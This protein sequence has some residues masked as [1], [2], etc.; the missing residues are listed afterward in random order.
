MVTPV[1]I[2]LAALG[3]PGYINLGH[4]VDLEHSYDITG[5]ETHAHSVL[6]TAWDNGIRYYDAARSYGL[7]E[8]FLS[9][10]LASR[11][12]QPDKVVVGSKWGYTYTAGWKVEAEKHEVK[13]H[14]L[15]VLRKQIEESRAYLGQYLKVYQIH[16]ATLD[17][18]VLENNEVLEQLGQLRDEGLVIG[19][20][21]SGPQQA[22]TL[23]KAM[24]IQIGGRPLFRSV[25][26][27]WNLLA[28]GSTDALSEAHAGGMG[29]IV[30]EALA[31]GRLTTRNDDPAFAAKRSL[32]ERVAAQAGVPLDALALAAVMARPWADIVLSGAARPSHLVDNLKALSVAWSGEMD[33][34]LA[35]LTEP[36]EQY[37]ETRGQLEWN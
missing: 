33:E 12:I 34:R 30:K 4:A 16:S 29:V 26:A 6:D 19:L 10:W 14:S 27:T 37:W 9:S 8:R 24:E 31:N 11:K 36:E 20:S 1:G 22:A 32:L 13:E 2:G 21:L 23:R 35:G 28:R 25:Q 3:R 7:A 17:S 5:M 15:P 18:G